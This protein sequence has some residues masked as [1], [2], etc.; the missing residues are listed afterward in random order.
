MCDFG[1]LRTL[2]PSPCHNL[3]LAWPR[4]VL[5]RPRPASPDPCLTLTRASPDPRPDSS[6]AFVEEFWWIFWGI[7]PWR[8]HEET[9]LLGENRRKKTTQKSVC[10]KRGTQKG[11]GHFFCFGHLF[12][13]I[14][15]AFL[16]FLVTFVPSPFCL[17]L[18]RQGEK[19]F[20]RVSVL[21]IFLIF[22]FFLP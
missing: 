2:G 5:T 17:P 14:L 7:I 22:A 13:A 15:V 10:R 3:S 4:P 21:L 6:Q 11:I 18:L 9:N 19:G 8:K 20:S 1:A 16:T 12:L